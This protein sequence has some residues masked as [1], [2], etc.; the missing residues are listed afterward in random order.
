MYRGLRTFALLDLLF[1]QSGPVAGQLG[2]QAVVQHSTKA[3]TPSGMYRLRFTYP[4]WIIVHLP[5]V[6]YVLYCCQSCAVGVRGR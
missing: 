6:L 3:D 2:R 4:S 1:I 5:Y